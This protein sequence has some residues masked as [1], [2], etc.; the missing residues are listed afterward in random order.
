[1]GS[2]ITFGGLDGAMCVAA[3]WHGWQHIV[4]RYRP[5]TLT[6]TPLVGHVYWAM[7]T[8][9]EVLEE[10]PHEKGSGRK[11]RTRKIEKR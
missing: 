11:L 8:V 7:E 6:W 3:G 2:S 5:D 4:N 1:M 9:L 10:K